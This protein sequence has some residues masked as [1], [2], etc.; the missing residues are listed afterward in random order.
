[1]CPIKSPQLARKFEGDASYLI[2]QQ[3]VEKDFMVKGD[4]HGSYVLKV[5][6][7]SLKFQK[8]ES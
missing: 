8:F 1:M 3:A 5:L 6:N 2:K 7:W 4:I